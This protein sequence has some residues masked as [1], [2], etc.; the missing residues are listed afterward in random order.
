LRLRAMSGPSC[1]I[2][3]AAHPFRHDEHAG[4]T[5]PTISVCLYA[6][7]RYVLPSARHRNR[8]SP[9]PVRDRL[10]FLRQSTQ[11]RHRDCPQLRCE[12]LLSV[13]TCIVLSLARCCGL[14]ISSG[15][16]EHEPSSLTVLQSV[17]GR[18]HLRAGPDCYGAAFSRRFAN[19]RRVRYSNLRQR[20][21][22]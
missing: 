18:A 14:S 16:D 4:A 8:H 11:P 13:R 17:P 2:T 19:S 1:D 5:R 10:F 9:R 12:V 6:R 3:E 20:S 22:F 7:L 21:V 15:A